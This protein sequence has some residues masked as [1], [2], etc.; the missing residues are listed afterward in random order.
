MVIYIVVLRVKMLMHK[1]L[2]LEY[3]W[4]FSLMDRI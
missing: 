4:E 1:V 3:A 2:K